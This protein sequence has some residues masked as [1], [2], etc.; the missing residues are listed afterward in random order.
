[1]IIIIGLLHSR[2][3]ALF[4]HKLTADRKLTETAN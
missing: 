4:S 1:M 3:I 2:K